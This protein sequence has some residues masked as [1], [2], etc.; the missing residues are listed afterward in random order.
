MLSNNELS[1]ITNNVEGTQS[2]RKRLKL[3][4]YIQSKT[5]PCGLLFLQETHSNSKAAQKW[6]KD[7]LGKVFF[8]NEKVF[9]YNGKTNS[10]G[11]LI[12][13]FGTEKFTV[14]KQQNKL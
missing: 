9:F 3:I 7:I 13:C 11:V 6:N 4:Q 5:G 1:L 8:Y 2:L 14:K 10:R 12:A